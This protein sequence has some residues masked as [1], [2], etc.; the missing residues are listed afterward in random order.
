MKGTLRPM[1]GSENRG[2]L[3]AIFGALSHPARRDILARLTGGPAKVTE[4]AAAFDISL[5]AVSR[6]LK[7]LERAGL[8]RRRRQ[9]R[10]HF[11]AYRGEPLRQVARWLGELA[12]P[13]TSS[14]AGECMPDS[15]MY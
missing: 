8:V 7:V 12:R 4:I 6:H 2:D 15:I 5:N 1:A 13:R 3:S 10:D 14:R 11:I 9:G